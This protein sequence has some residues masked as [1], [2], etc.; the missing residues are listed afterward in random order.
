MIYILLCFL[1]FSLMVWGS[2]SRYIA[3]RYFG[4][5]VGFVGLV[6]SLINLLSYAIN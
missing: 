2:V 6:F 3:T 5:Y 4:V 1:S